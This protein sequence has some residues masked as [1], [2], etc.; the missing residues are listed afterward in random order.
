MLHYSS[1]YHT[2]RLSYILSRDYKELFYSTIKK[3]RNK[4]RKGREGEG[5]E[6]KGRE[7]RKKEIKV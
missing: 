3:E 6:G 1:L 2:I 5:R 7:E 4:E